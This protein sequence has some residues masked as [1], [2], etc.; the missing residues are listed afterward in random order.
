MARARD[1]FAVGDVMCTLTV[2]YQF[3]EP[4]FTR[5]AMET[6]DRTRKILLRMKYD[7]LSTVTSFQY[8]NDRCVRVSYYFECICRVDSCSVW[9]SQPVHMGAR[10]HC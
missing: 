8:W 9:L 5:Y 10:E 4:L 3:F 7:D 2:M 6:A 1:S